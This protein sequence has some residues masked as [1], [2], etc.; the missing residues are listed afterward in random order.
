MSHGTDVGV[1]GV[2]DEAKDSGAEPMSMQRVLAASLNSAKKSMRLS[3]RNSPKSSPGGDRGARGAVFA[4]DAPGAV[5]CQLWP[6][7]EPRRGQFLER[8]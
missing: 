4:G 8:Y 1:A 5:L 2:V 6:V 3:C 7:P